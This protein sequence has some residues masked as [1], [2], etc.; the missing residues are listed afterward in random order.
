VY[1]AQYAP[2]GIDSNLVFGIPYSVWYKKAP[3]IIENITCKVRSSNK[4]NLD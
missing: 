3:K 2:S 4:I 1:K